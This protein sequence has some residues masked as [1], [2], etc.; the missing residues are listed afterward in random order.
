MSDSL[1]MSRGKHREKS[2]EGR[3]AYRWEKIDHR[4][5]IKKRPKKEGKKKIC[6]LKV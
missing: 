5:K 4:M 2:R 3:E 6:L 1:G